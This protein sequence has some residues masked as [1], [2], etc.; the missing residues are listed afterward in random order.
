MLHGMIA[1]VG[2]WFGIRWF[3]KHQDKFPSPKSHKM[4]Y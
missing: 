1:I 3:S 2:M 4:E